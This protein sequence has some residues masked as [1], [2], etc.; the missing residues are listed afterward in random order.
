MSES[1]KKY[2]LDTMVMNIYDCA[3]DLTVGIPLLKKH[4]LIKTRFS[5]GEV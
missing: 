3:K 5:V 2:D 1:W 4:D